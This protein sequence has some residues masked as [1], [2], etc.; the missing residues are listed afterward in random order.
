MFGKF[1]AGCLAEN[2]ID[3]RN[4][5]VDPIHNTTFAFVS[6][7]ESGDR[8]FSFCRRFGA[9]LYIEESEVDYS[10]IENSKIFHFGSL[11][12]TAEP[13][14]NA[15]EKALE[16]AKKSGCV[17]TYDPNYRP[18]LWESEELAVEQM[19]GH[20]K[21]ADIV[22]VSREEA[23]L[24]SGCADIA[25][26][27]GYF[28][29]QGISVILV[30]DGANGVNY[31]ACGRCGFIPAIKVRAVDTTGAGDIFFG[32]FIS[33]FI[34]SKK[35]FGELSFEDVTAFVEKAV[36]VSGLSTMKKGAVSSIPDVTI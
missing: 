35:A 10:I 19:G 5:V 7:D 12:L 1:L 11:S 20:L 9:D 26:A 6:L 24:L 15:T 36:E 14:R 28:R 31:S 23:L 17:I 18:P 29:E 2:G 34:K 8:D 30:T 25:D 33:C 16:R 32:T 21:Y 3:G 22:K 27:I 13:A 4:L